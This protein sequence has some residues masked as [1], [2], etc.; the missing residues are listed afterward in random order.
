MRLLA[1]DSHD[2]SEF[3]TG[4]E[5]T[6]R[7][8]SGGHH[9]EKLNLL[10]GHGVNRISLGVQ[11]FDDDKLRTLERG[12]AGEF[13]SDVIEMAAERIDNV[14]IDLIFAAPRVKSSTVGSSD[15]ETAIALPI[16]H[17]STYALTFEKG[18]SFWSR[19]HRGQTAIARRIVGSRD[20]S[21]S[22]AR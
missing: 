10:A 6:R 7:S 21:N 11:S 17:L 12:H 19:Q 14:S 3:E 1:I 15:L 8:E 5:W 16:R 20:V 18:T 4:V 2:D 9:H 22:P 13:A